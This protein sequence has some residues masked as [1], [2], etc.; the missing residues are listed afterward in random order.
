MAKDFN[1][2]LDTLENKNA[3][4]FAESKNVEFS[5]NNKGMQE[6]TNSILLYNSEVSINLL[7]AYHNWLFENF[8]ISSKKK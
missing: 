4:I 7:K 1:D 2:F 5:L 6:Y 3:N 8:D